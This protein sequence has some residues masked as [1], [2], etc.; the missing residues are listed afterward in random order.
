MSPYLSRQLHDSLL[1][2]LF[3][4]QLSLLSASEFGRDFVGRCRRDNDGRE[5]IS[6][7]LPS[8]LALFEPVLVGHVE[9]CI[10]S[11]PFK[12]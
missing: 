3:E 2:K 6:Y 9:T 8:S 5:E 1:A 11:T 7:V 4:S 12:L 10:V